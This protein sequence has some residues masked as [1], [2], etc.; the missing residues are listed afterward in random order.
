MERCSGCSSSELS[1]PT[2]ALTRLDSGFGWM[3]WGWA[4]TM[5]AACTAETVTVICCATYDVIFH[6]S[7]GAPDRR[8]RKEIARPPSLRVVLP[9]ATTRNRQ[10][11]TPCIKQLEGDKMLKSH[12]HFEF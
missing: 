3:E 10:E 7:I 5:D 6:S 11:P 4:G 8:Y 9:H 1:F 2:Q 12:A